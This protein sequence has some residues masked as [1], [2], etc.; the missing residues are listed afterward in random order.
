MVNPLSFGVLSPRNWYTTGQTE[1]F[2]VLRVKMSPLVYY[3][4]FPLFPDL[5][6]F[7]ALRWDS[8]LRFLFFSRNYPFILLY[9]SKHGEVRPQKNA[10]A[11]ENKARTGAK[12]GEKKGSVP[13]FEPWNSGCPTRV[14]AWDRSKC[15]IDSYY[16]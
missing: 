12:K 11:S 7:A 4:K 16:G 15:V 2:G 14:R 3:G 1:T 8:L 6:L 5:A 13:G 10:V 9:S